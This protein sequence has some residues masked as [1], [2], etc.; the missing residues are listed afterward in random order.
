MSTKIISL[1]ATP[2]EDCGAQ[3]ADYLRVYGQW[4]YFHVDDLG[5]R[6]DQSLAFGAAAG[7]GYL[8]AYAD[9]FE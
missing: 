4:C 7:Y 9:T 5:Q 6:L 8:G 1:L 2:G 3:S